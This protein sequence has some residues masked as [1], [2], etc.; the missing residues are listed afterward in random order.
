MNASAGGS[1]MRS[2]AA[3]RLRPYA[4]V[5]QLPPSARAAMGDG[6]EKLD[7]H[8]RAQR[9]RRR[10]RPRRGSREVTVSSRTV[11]QTYATAHA[12]RSSC[13]RPAGRGTVLKVVH[14]EARRSAR[15]RSRQRRHLRVRQAR[16]P[17]DGHDHHDTTSRLQGPRRA[18]SRVRDDVSTRS[19]RQRRGRPCGDHVQLQFHTTYGTGDVPLQPGPI[20]SI[21]DP[22]WNKAPVL[23]VSVV[24]S[25]FKGKTPPTREAARCR[26]EPRLPAVHRALLV[27]DGSGPLKFESTTGDRS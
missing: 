3:H 20:A 10:V 22:N 21:D 17:D 2:R 5:S 25:N 6:A 27:G 9:A 13:A 12:C 11:E 18:N 15:T 23:P 7:A 16:R 26:Q 14:R 8:E 24:D 1:F 19:N 4:Q